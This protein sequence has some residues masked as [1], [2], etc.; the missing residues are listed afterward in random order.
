MS[1]FFGSI[2]LQDKAPMIF[3]LNHNGH[4]NEKTCP[5][6]CALSLYFPMPY[7]LQDKFE[8]KRLQNCQLFTLSDTAALSG[9]CE[10]LSS[11]KVVPFQLYSP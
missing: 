7:L 10:S 3:S 2:L 9:Q 8:S 11:S 1:D 5:F 6:C 4:V